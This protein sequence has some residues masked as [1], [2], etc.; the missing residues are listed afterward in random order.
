MYRI[1]IESDGTLKGSKLYLMEANNKLF[2]L[3]CRKYSI[4]FKDDLT[5]IEIDI[6]ISNISDEK[7]KLL[8]KIRDES[9]KYSQTW[10]VSGRFLQL[11]FP[12]YELC[13]NNHIGD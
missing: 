9:D 3:F 5:R 4:K 8:I 12:I 2:E 13:I 1:K 11:S 6:S 7:Y 10:R